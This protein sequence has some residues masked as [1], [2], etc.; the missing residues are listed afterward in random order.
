MDWWTELGLTPADVG[1]EV[2]P[3]TTNPGMSDLTGGVLTDAGS[4]A[5]WAANMAGG[6][7]GW[8][9]KLIGPAANAAV[10]AAGG[11][12][13]AGGNDILSKILASLGIDPSSVLGSGISS[14]LSLA[15]RSAPGLMALDYANK[16]P[17]IDVSGLEGI[18]GKVGG[19]Q[20]AIIKAATDPLQAN[21]AAGYGDLLQSQGLRGIRGSSF[22][23]TDIANYISRTGTALS[24]AAANAASGSLAL[25][26]TLA[27]QIAK[28]KAEAQTTKNNL[29]GKA[30]DVLGRGVSPGGFGSQLTLAS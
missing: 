12:G 23:D 4:T 18:L 21:I 24:G 13:S 10:K 20:D 1:M 14:G 6:A 25:Q 17:G 8:L 11:A 30:F 9:E 26:G 15:A 5:S 16:Q 3:W 27:A 2:S 29:F 19:N 28:L 7:Q 22:G